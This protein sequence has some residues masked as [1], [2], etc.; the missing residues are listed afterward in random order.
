MVLKRKIINIEECQKYL[1]DVGQT[2]RF[3]TKQVWILDWNK[4]NKQILNLGQLSMQPYIF[5]MNQMQIT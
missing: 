4:T 1:K 3:I 2:I 5:Q